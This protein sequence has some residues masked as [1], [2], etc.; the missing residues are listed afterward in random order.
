MQI[1][2]S[3]SYFE[4]Y[5]IWYFE[6]LTVCIVLVLLRHWTW[7]QIMDHGIM[8]YHGYRGLKLAATDYG[9]TRDE[10]NWWRPSRQTAIIIRV[11]TE[12][13]L[14]E[15]EWTTMV[16]SIQSTSSQLK[17]GQSQEI[18]VRRFP[19]VIVS[20]GSNGNFVQAMAMSHPEPMEPG[21]VVYFTED[22]GWASK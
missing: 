20:T 5:N 9:L 12:D 13:E 8:M 19:L 11:S 6:H 1:P 3:T 2:P 21:S 15:R 18:E 16:N 7:L 4:W 14:L 17:F 10:Q 22:M